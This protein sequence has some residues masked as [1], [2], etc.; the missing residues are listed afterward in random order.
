MSFGLNV[1]TSKP[2]FVTSNIAK[3][4]V[5]LSFSIIVFCAFLSNTLNIAKPEISS[6]KVLL[7]LS[8]PVLLVSTLSVLLG[9][10][11][12]IYLNS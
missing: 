10:K 12:S 2:V 11:V 3:F 6:T 5:N 7:F 9:R 8:I 4:W 1:T